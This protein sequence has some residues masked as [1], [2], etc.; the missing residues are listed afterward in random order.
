MYPN[1]RIEESNDYI[2][3]F[4]YLTDSK[5]EEMEAKYQ[6]TIRKPNGDEFVLKP[7]KNLLFIKLKKFQVSAEW[8]KYKPDTNG[9]GCDKM[10]KRE[11]LLKAENGYLDGG[12]LTI[13]CS[14]T[15]KQKSVFLCILIKI[16]R[17]IKVKN[18]WVPECRLQE[19]VSHLFETGQFADCKIISDNGK[20][21]FKVNIKFNISYD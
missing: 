16:I 4:L 2:A 9:W 19:D 11:D 17:I 5:N 3:I 10:I 20:K 1:G 18:V 15:V 13:V 7:S 21:E 14:V 12:Q 6:I 8:R